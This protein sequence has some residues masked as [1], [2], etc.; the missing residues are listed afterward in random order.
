IDEA[1]AKLRIE[2]DSLPTEIDVVERKIRQ[3]EI[4]RVALAKETDPAS[5]ERLADLDQELANQRETLAGMKAHWQSEKEAIANIR[6]L[7]E[8]LEALRGEMERSTDLE[9]AAEIRY[10]RIPEVERQVAAATEELNRL[11]AE[12]KM[13][14][15][16][17]DEEDIAEVVSRWTGVPV[18]RLMEGEVQKL[19]RLEEVLHQR[20]IGQEEAVT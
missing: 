10:G 8:Q 16:E 12:N 20:V 15:E 17:V 11:Q 13:L 19:I 1:A 7:K 2:I 6:E 14:K 18:S 9:R 3:L 4:E 5:K